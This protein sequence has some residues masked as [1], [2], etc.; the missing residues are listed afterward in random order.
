MRERRKGL[1]NNSEHLL[2]LN[3]DEHSKKSVSVQFTH[4]RSVQLVYKPEN[5]RHVQACAIYSRCTRYKLLQ[6]SPNRHQIPG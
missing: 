2:S 4:Y 6:P 5:A 3:M 1:Q